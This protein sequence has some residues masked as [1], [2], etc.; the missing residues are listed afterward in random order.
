MSNTEGLSGSNAPVNN[1]PLQPPVSNGNTA[2]APLPINST[3]APV[4]QTMNPTTGQSAGSN[5]GTGLT[6]DQVENYWIQAGGSPQSAAMAAAVADAESGLNAAAQ[7]TNPD[8][9]IGIGLWLTPQNG[10]PPGSTDP[11]ASARGAI[12][13]S[14]NG[15]DWTQWCSTWSDNNCGQNGGTYLGSGSNA[16]M[17]LG[18]QASSP[19]YGQIGSVPAGSG[20]GASSATSTGGSTTP[21]SS[22]HSLILFVVLIVVVVVVFYLSRKKGGEPDG[23]GRDLPHVE[24]DKSSGSIYVPAHTRPAPKRDI[25]S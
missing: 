8:G 7:R 20:V 5:A 16:L 18:T 24:E 12:Q 9:T 3:T 25:G 4:Q 21:S 17:S 2:P 19:S 1:Q 6:F 13:L 23:P 11:L 10:T 14:N 15:T 22:S